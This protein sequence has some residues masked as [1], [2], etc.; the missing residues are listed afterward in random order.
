M[1]EPDGRNAA[2]DVSDSE[3][4]DSLFRR[5]LDYYS[6]KG[7]SPNYEKAA[8]LYE[9]AAS[10]GLVL[11]MLNLGHMYYDGEGVARDYRKAFF[12]YSKAA[13]AGLVNAMELAA[14]MYEDG[15]GVEENAEEARRLY[16]AAAWLGGWSGQGYIASRY[17]KNINERQ[18]LIEAAAWWSLSATEGNSYAEIQLARLNDGLSASEKALVAGRSKELKGMV[19]QAISRHVTHLYLPVASRTID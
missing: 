1:A 10:S 16:E 11:A 4:P 5:G 6:G 3:S 18:D 14:S 12:W 8:E 19:N 7:A 15:R 2:A 13:D 17:S 9:K